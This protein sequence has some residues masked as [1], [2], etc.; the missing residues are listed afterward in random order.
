MAFQPG[1]LLKRPRPRADGRGME[2]FFGLLLF[3][4]AIYLFATVATEG[5]DHAFGGVFA[6]DAQMAAEEGAQ[7]QSPDVAAVSPSRQPVTERVRDRVQGAVDEYSG[8]I[9]AD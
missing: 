8:R 7:T 9:G 3:I 5:L 6:G 2:R 1:S 4:T